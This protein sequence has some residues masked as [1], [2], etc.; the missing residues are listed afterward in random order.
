MS[1]IRRM[2]PS[3]MM[4]RYRGDLDDRTMWYHLAPS[5][6]AAS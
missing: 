5:T 3:R 2:T 4:L 1:M 6:F